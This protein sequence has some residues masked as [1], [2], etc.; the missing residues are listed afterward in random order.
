MKKIMTLAAIF[1]AVMMGITS[2]NPDDTKPEQKPDTEQGGENNGG[3]N[4]GGENNG[5]E[6]AEYES[7]ITIDGTFDDWAAIDASKLAVATNY[8]ETKGG[9]KVMKVYADEVF[10]NVYV[11]FDFDFVADRG[12][13]AN[14]FSL[15]L[16]T[17]KERGGYNMW[18]DLCIEYMI[19]GTIFQDDAFV[20]WDGGMYMWTGE[21]HGEGWNW[22]EA[23]SSVAGQGAGADNKYELCIM[24]ETLAGVMEFGDKF[25]M[26]ADVQQNWDSAGILPNAAVTDENPTGDAE[27]LEV[28]FVK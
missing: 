27:M 3:E 23:L 13:S 5:G 10:I 2:C 28:T 7:P 18:S 8:S 4:N 24:V 19:Q 25:W 12:N 22:G 17:D 20:S 15:Y 26:G 14:P 11:E 1:A 9:L 16:C 21:V 6:E